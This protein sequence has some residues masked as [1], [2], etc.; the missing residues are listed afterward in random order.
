MIVVIPI[1]PLNN[2]RPAPG[3]P[4]GKVENNRCSLGL[5]GMVCT[6]EHATNKGNDCNG[7]ANPQGSA[8]FNTTIVVCSLVSRLGFSQLDDSSA[9]GDRNRLARHREILQRCSAPV[10]H[11]AAVSTD[12]LQRPSSNLEQGR[13]ESHVNMVKTAAGSR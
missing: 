5:L 3:H 2:S 1:P 13:P 11:S 8:F 9:Y 4:P 7:K 12:F 10:P 6:F